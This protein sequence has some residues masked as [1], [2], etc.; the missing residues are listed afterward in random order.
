VRQWVTYHGIAINVAPNLEHFE[1]IV[2]C[3][4]SEH[5]V[6]SMTALGLPITMD[7]LDVALKTVF[8]EIFGL[9][10][11]EMLFDP[12]TKAPTIAPERPPEKSIEETH[13]VFTL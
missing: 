12:V 7:D 5:G 6:T 3:G 11:K 13:P 1:G 2:P 9:A 4:I 8:D 10:P